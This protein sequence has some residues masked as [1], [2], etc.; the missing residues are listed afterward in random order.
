MHKL[1]N[2]IL[3][4]SLKPS[5]YFSREEMMDKIHSRLKYIDTEHLVTIKIENPLRK[6]DSHE[7]RTF[8]SEKELIDHSGIDTCPPEY[9]KELLEL[10]NGGVPKYKIEKLCCKHLGLIWHDIHSIYINRTSDNE[11]YQVCLYT[12]NKS[13]SNCSDEEIKLDFFQVIADDL[14]HLLEQIIKE[15]DVQKIKESYQKLVSFRDEFKKSFPS[16]QYGKIVE[17]FN[18]MNS[19]AIKR[20]ETLF[21]DVVSSIQVAS[22]E[23]IRW[24]G[25]ADEFVDAFNN[26]SPLKN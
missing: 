11:Y 20:I 3:Y 14:C 5:E 2:K 17:I 24:E 13:F 25:T 15:D 19:M 18:S 7:I 4:G 23:K 8:N 16:S 1:I 10:Q 21:P 22:L 6:I 26:N 12:R 9:D